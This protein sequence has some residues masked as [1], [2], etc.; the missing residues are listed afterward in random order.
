ML[1]VMAGLLGVD[2]D[3]TE[4]ERAVEMSWEGWPVACEIE[5]GTPGN[6]TILWDN[7][8]GMVEAMYEA[9]PA[10]EKEV[11]GQAVE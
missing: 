2:A 5:M 6:T 7:Y 3:K 4:V 11:K 8:D 10:E 9:L 1:R